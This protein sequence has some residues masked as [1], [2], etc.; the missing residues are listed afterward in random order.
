MT[1]TTAALAAATFAT[2]TV[3][4]TAAWDGQDRSIEV[5]NRTSYDILNIFSAREGRPWGRDLLGDETILQSGYYVTVN[6]EDNTNACWFQF[7]AVFEDG[8]EVVSDIINACT[9]S[10]WDFTDEE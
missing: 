8:D 4:S 5:H 1:Q 10:S 6:P 9:E 3:P 7:K 2:S